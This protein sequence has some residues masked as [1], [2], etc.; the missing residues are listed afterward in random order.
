MLPIPVADPNQLFKMLGINITNNFE[1]YNNTIKERIDTFFEVLD[2]L[3]IHPEIKHLILHLCGKPK[4]LYY[5]E[6]TP[7]QY[8]KEV[9]ELFDRKAKESFATLIDIKDSKLI[10]DD[11]LYD[12]FGGNLPHYSKHHQALYNN[13]VANALTGGRM[14]NNIHGLLISSD[15]E[16]FKSPECSHDRLWTHWL[17][18]TSTKLHQLAPYEYTTALAIRCS[19]APDLI[20]DK[21]GQSVR[22]G[23]SSLV[24]VRKELARHLCSCTEMS[25]LEYANRH[26]YVKH[27][28]RSVLTQYGIQSDNEPNY[29]NYATGNCRPDI[30]VRMVGTKNIAID[31][32]IVKPDANEIGAAAKRAAE[33]KEKIHG[34]AVSAFEH[35]F[36]PFALETTGHM[37]ASCFAFFKLVRNEVH[38]HHRIQFQRDFFGAIS[39]ALARFR[40]HSMISAA[41]QSLTG[42]S[43]I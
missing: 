2:N 3:T 35:V 24:N 13:C 36:I 30:T 12:K 39:T 21:M 37:D 25:K 11:I 22:C 40:A 33:A 14:Q 4:L 10:S 20:I 9:A 6:T 7:P 17:N 28:I 15:I 26:T 27:A 43:T 8:G 23:C 34:A 29:Y 16:K 41:N 38:F 19:L 18:S 5:C 42:S 32:T 1:E 31:L